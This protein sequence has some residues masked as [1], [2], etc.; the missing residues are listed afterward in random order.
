MR[1]EV[2]DQ[3]NDQLQERF[4]QLDRL[5]ESVECIGTALG[6][7][8]PVQVHLRGEVV[9]L[10]NRHGR[11]EEDLGGVT[12]AQEQNGRHLEE[13]SKF[14]HAVNDRVEQLSSHVGELSKFQHAVNSRVAMLDDRSRLFVANAEH[15]VF[16]LKAG[17]LISD[18]VL[19]QHCWDEHILTAL[20]GP[21][22][23]RNGLAVDVGAHLGLLTVALAR[24]FR[25]V[26]SFEP[27]EFNY[28]LLAANAALNGLRN[29]EC[30]HGALFSG[31]VELSLGK[32]EEQEVELS[33]TPEGNFDGLSASNLGAYKFTPNGTGI[34]CRTARTLDSYNL[35]EVVF[36]KIDVQGAD[37][38]VIAGAS[39]TIRRCRPV[40]VFE[41]EDE[42]SKSFRVSLADV[43]RQLEGEG[44]SIELLKA[45]NDKQQDFLAV[46]QTV[47]QA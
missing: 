20:D 45:H 30:I 37:G 38:E 6:Q 28:R 17:D 39:E 3:A 9:A 47:Q 21:L 25:R 5:R 43:R 44:Y 2:S 31:S 23:G 36:I 16:L 40:I 27:N 29:V 26:V 15:G 18:A 8:V 11:V 19:N 46:P 33:L 12:A 13:L 4:S 42:L 24:R 34:F 22:Q 1:A 14:L 35:D 32:N 41:W 7:M 10:N